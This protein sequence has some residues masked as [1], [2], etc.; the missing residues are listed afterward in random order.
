MFA[1]MTTEQ[2]RITIMFR[3][4]R[5]KGS[6]NYCFGKLGMGDYLRFLS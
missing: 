3:T 4:R 5:E 6:I 1:N 2:D